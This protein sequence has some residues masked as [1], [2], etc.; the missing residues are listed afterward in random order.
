MLYYFLL[1]QFKNDLTNLKE[2]YTNPYYL[3]FVGYLHDEKG[4]FKYEEISKIQKS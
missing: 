2:K 1:L 4:H 3:L